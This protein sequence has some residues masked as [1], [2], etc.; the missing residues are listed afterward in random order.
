MLRSVSIISNLNNIFNK[1]LTVIGLILMLSF[2]VIIMHIINNKSDIRLIL[3][4]NGIV[5]FCIVLIL[6]Y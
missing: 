3:F 2:R 4:I 1:Y 6:M 5:L